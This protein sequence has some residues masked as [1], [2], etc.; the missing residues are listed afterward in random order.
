MTDDRRLIT[1]KNQ[2]AFGHRFT[3]IGRRAVTIG[4]QVF[5]HH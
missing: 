5:G 1:A 4:D 2:K 3:V